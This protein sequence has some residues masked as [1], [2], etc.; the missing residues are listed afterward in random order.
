VLGGVRVKLDEH[1]PESARIVALIHGCTGPLFFAAVAGM[2]AVTS[3]RWRES[4][5]L[6]TVTAP[7]AKVFRLAVVT[8][9]LAYLQLVVGAVVRHSPLMLS[10]VAANVFQIAV[11]FHVVLALAVTFHVLL[12]AHRCFWSGLNRGSSVAVAVF[13]GLQLLLGVSTW[14]LKYGMPGWASGVIGETGHFNRASD[15]AGTAIVTAHG[16]VGSLLFAICVS[17]AVH[18]GRRVGIR[19]QLARPSAAPVAGALA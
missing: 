12:L 10:D 19:S 13:I 9:V 1:S 18:L 16:A 14:M 8:A 17:M 15:S 7:P 4:A 11:Y 2:I 5:A 3:R 6:P